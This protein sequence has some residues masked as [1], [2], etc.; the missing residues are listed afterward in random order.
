MMP[1]RAA[2]WISARMRLR[3]QQKQIEQQHRHEQCIQK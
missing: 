3:A 1:C 2:A